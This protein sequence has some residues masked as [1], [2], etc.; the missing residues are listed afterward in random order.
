MS[1]TLAVDLREAGATDDLQH[2]VNYAEVFRCNTASERSDETCQCRMQRSWP[3]IM[4]MLR[5]VGDF[6]SDVAAVVEGPPR[7]LIESLASAIADTILQ[8]HPLVQVRLFLCWLCSC[9]RWS[10]AGTAGWMQDIKVI[11]LI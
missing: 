10:G 11:R 5:D 9:V 8:R 6:D 1:A 4:Y 7:H 3:A 2:T